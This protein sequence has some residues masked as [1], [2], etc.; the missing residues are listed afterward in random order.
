MTAL[1][2]SLI[3]FSRVRSLSSGNE[4]SFYTLIIITRLLVI[5]FFVLNLFRA[6]EYVVL[7]ILLCTLHVY[8]CSVWSLI[9]KRGPICLRGSV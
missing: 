8:I 2:I 3:S 9:V 7:F 6:Y 5:S 4:Y 1:S